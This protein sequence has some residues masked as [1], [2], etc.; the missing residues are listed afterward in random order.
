MPNSPFD[1]SAGRARR[2]SVKQSS[3]PSHSLQAAAPLRA[4]DIAARYRRHASE[5]WSTP[6]DGRRQM[7]LRPPA[8][9]EVPPRETC[10]RPGFVPTAVRSVELDAPLADV[11][12]GVSSTGSPYGD[13]A[14]LARLHGE[15]L[16]FVTLGLRNGQLAASDL[17]AGLWATLGDRIREHAERDGCLTVESLGPETLVRGLPPVGK[18]CQQ[19][20]QTGPD[21][22]FVS[23]IVPTR[24]R[25]ADLADCLHS[26]RGLRYPRFELLVVDNGPSDPSTRRLV[27][28]V[29]R[30]DSRLRYI[31]EHRPGS[32]VAR[33]AGIAHAHGDIFDFT[34]DD[35]IVETDWLDQ[36]VAPLISDS[37]VD[38]VTGLVLPAEFETQ[39]Q[40]WFEAFGGFGKGF[41]RRVYDLER[42]RGDDRFLYPYCG[43]AFGSGN[44]MAFR[45]SRLAAIG[46]FDPALGAGSP[47]LGGADI[48]AF[49]H[50]ILRGG[51]L[52]YEPRAICWHKHRRDE[53]ALRR[54]LFAYGVALTA[55]LMKWLLRDPRL[56]R[57]L[58]RE[59]A[60]ILR[61]AVVPA[62]SRLRN[63]PHLPRELARVE[64]RGF[65]VGP[66][67]YVRSVRWSRRKGLSAVLP[68]G[69]R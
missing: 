68:Y 63:R 1:P 28:E 33:N 45:K 21:P 41:E 51:R 4:V 59:L 56:P 30:E 11:V 32:S 66:A 20:C 38:V 26:L 34:D 13:V 50:L 53:A 58:L 65:L 25:V 69:H 18:N 22:P 12:P 35:V 10:R 46:G 8:T 57:V 2:T 14:V 64:L 5:R 44:S 42:H 7:T 29:G 3:A 24:A 60:A 36:L 49:T 47:A 39:A 31:A 67:M 55:I 48:E 23:V 43:G 62:A 52:V 6:D 19:V 37:K 27:T 54:Q 15:P 17:A 61:G 16:G 40:R 9:R